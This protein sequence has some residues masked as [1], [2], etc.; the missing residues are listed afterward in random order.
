[1][2]ETEQSLLYWESNRRAYFSL[3]QPEQEPKPSCER[4]CF[5]CPFPDC[6]YSGND[7]TD[8]ERK[9]LK[10]GHPNEYPRREKNDADQ[11]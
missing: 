9:C 2:T 8:F 10:I 6:V 4:D 5:S 1:M 7:M 11:H 3:V